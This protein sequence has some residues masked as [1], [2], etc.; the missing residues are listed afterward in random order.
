VKSRDLPPPPPPP[1]NRT[2]DE[3][4]EYSNSPTPSP[5]YQPRYLSGMFPFDDT[6][7]LLVKRTQ[8]G[9][10]SIQPKDSPTYEEHFTPK[11][12]KPP[13][14]PVLLPLGGGGGGGRSLLF[15]LIGE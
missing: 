14:P 15:T 4:S 1:R 8:T 3:D 10:S 6:K 12:G 13:V 7:P 9:E 5:H 2:N 11:G